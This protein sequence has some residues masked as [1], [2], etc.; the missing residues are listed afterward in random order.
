L[1]STKK[2]ILTLQ[3]YLASNKTPS[4][5]CLLSERAIYVPAQ[6]RLATGFVLCGKILELENKTNHSA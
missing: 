1:K 2:L 5:S 4:H 6:S 3:K